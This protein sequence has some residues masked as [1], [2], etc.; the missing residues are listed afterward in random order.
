MVPPTPAHILGG[1]DGGAV[2]AESPESIV[3]EWLPGESVIRSAA[4]VTADLVSR[5][6]PMIS[7]M[8][9]TS[10]PRPSGRNNTLAVTVGQ[11]PVLV[12]LC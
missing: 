6:S 3:A 2:A 4:S 12:F 5:W 1:A 11:Q 9:I 8:S 7:A 10:L